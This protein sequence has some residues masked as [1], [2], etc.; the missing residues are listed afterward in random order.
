MQIACAEELF[1]VN[2]VEILIDPNEIAA[3]CAGE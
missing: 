1:T 2:K 3:N